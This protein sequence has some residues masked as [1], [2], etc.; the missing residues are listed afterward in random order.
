MKVKVLEYH[1]YKNGIV[2]VHEYNKRKGKLKLNPNYEFHKMLISNSFQF[3]V[4]YQKTYEIEK[5][6]GEK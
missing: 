6:E 5:T 4:V 2:K 3:P 1:R